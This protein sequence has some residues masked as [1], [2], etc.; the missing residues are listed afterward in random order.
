[1]LSSLNPDIIIDT[2]FWLQSHDI[3]SQIF[4]SALVNKFLD[5]GHH[6]L[7]IFND[8]DKI[9]HSTMEIKRVVESVCF[10]IPNDLDENYRKRFEMG[11]DR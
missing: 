5:S 7:V 1:M 2:K 9:I 4:Q 10:G 8:I 11:R 3:N 6:S